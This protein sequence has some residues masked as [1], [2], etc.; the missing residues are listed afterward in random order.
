MGARHHPHN[1]SILI[2]RPARAVT[3]RLFDISLPPDGDTTPPVDGGCRV[4]V[5]GARGTEKSAALATIVASARLSG[6][7][8]LYLPDGDRLR[9][10]GLYI[11]PN[12]RREGVYDLQ[13]S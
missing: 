9:K 8:L 1:Q 3:R 11:V 13:R 6:H 10:N 7:I 2:R 12:E 5:R 4:Y